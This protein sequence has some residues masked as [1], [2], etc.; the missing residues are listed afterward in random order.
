MKAVIVFNFLI[1]MGVVYGAENKGGLKDKGRSGNTSTPKIVITPAFGTPVPQR[2]LSKK[3]ENLLPETVIN[4][5][6]INRPQTVKS[7]PGVERV[8]SQPLISAS[9]VKTPYPTS[10]PN[11][12]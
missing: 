3:Q 5:T 10:T 9:V 1:C 11:K 4:Q 6:A 7:Q 8:K 12:K 2:H